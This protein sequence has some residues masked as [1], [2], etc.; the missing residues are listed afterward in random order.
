MWLFQSLWKSN[1]SHATLACTI[2]IFCTCLQPQELMC[3][4]SWYMWALQEWLCE[5][6]KLRKLSFLCQYSTNWGSYCFNYLQLPSTLNIHVFETH[7]YSVFESLHMNFIISMSFVWCHVN[8][9]QTHQSITT[10]THTQTHTQG[11]PASLCPSCRERVGAGCRPEARD[12][13]GE[14]QRARPVRATAGRDGGGPRGE[15]GAERSEERRG[16]PQDGRRTTERCG[17]LRPL[18]QSEEDRETEV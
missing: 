8:K 11:S 6:N 16:T 15:W 10:N 1:V 7:P 18:M 9:S 3:N 14:S 2:T 17:R 13:S 5:R 4:A 12:L